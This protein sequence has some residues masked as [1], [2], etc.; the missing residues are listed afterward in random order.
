M[1][2]IAGE[3]NNTEEK[4]IIKYESHSVVIAGILKTQHK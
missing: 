4:K 1:K 2:I 3:K